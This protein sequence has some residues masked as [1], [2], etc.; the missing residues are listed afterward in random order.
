LAQICIAEGQTTEWPGKQAIMDG[1]RHAI[2]EFVK[3]NQSSV[4][5]G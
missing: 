3:L 1:T 5:N 4:N 2:A